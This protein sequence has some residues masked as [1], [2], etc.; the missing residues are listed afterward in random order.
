MT[1]Q[2]GFIIEQALGH[3][4]HGQ[5][6]QKNI[7][8]DPSI[9]AYWGLPAW[10]T[11][12]PSSK[13]P[14][15]KSNWTVQAG[16]QTRRALSQI[17]RQA[18]LD[19]LFFHTQVTATLSQDWLRR[20]PSVVSLDATPQQYDSLGDTYAHNRGPEWLE[21]R[22]WLLNRD[23]FKQAKRLVTWSEWA[24]QGLVDEY[25]V[26]AE[27]ITVIPPGVNVSEWIPSL[28]RQAEEKYS[29]H[30]TPYGEIVRILFVGGDLPR[31]GGLLLLE[32]FRT[33]RHELA[34]QYLEKATA[35][36]L[37]LVTKYPLP[38]EPGLFVYNQMQPNS[39][40]LKRLYFNSQIFC[41]PTYGDCL[42]MV[43]SEAGAA[44]LP[45]IS[46]Q[47]AAIP[48]IVRDGETGF[49]VPPG[50]LS[51][52]TAALRRLVYDPPLRE[53]LGACATE[54]VRRE[55]DAGK[56]AALLIDLLKMTAAEGVKG[57]QKY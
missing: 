40:E 12:G 1:Y 39:P 53:R 42:P 5:N 4:T 26:P 29:S 15:Y 9:Q 54:V 57:Q 17:N 38:A 51:D 30:N 55:Y 20:I 43:L 14:F 52:L 33:L 28:V 24:K 23:C 3:I 44:G 10:K 27:K 8:R 37:H 34:D 21:R 22:K 11:S 50:D 41:L 32:A 13:I 35:L 47:V 49:L 6:L 18:R 25:Q 46:T 2:I 31:K 45:L 19:A 36:E 56:N 16:L 48:E 7:A